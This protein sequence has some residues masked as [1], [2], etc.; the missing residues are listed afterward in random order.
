MRACL[1]CG[2]PY[3]YR[4]ASAVSRPDHCSD[5]CHAAAGVRRALKATICGV[6][7]QTRPRFVSRRGTVV[8]SHACL[9]RLQSIDK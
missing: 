6:C 1:E 9:V 7:L 4:H 3:Q 2:G 5:E 8:C